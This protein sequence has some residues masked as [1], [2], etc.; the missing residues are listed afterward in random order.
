MSVCHM[1]GGP[2]HAT[3]CEPLNVG[4]GNQIWV[5]CKYVFWTADSLLHL[6]DYFVLKLGMVM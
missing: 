4:V 2:C 1:C 6:T 5:Q 3:C